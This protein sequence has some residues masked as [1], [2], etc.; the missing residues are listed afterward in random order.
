[1]TQPRSVCNFQEFCLIVI[2][3]VLDA[4]HSA[5]GEDSF[6]GYQADLTT[7]SNSVKLQLTQKQT[8]PLA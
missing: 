2:I 5:A 8:L 4:V 1:M 6:L 3:W 7:T